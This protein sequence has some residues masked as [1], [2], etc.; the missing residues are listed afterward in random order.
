MTKG[1]GIGS[2]ITKVRAGKYKLHYSEVR[3][4]VLRSTYDNNTS[5]SEVRGDVLR[6]TYDN[7]SQHST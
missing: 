7:P 1:P 6:S 2:N 3:G 4:D 5:Y